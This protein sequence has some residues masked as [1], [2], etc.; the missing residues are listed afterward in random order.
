MKKILPLIC[1]LLVSFGAYAAKTPKRFKNPIFNNI[2]WTENKNR[3]NDT[4]LTP[5]YIY[6]LQEPEYD[7]V[8]E[9]ITEDDKGVFLKC[10]DAHPEVFGP[11]IEPSV[12]YDMYYIRDQSFDRKGRPTC[13]VWYCSF[14][15][16]EGYVDFKY[17]ASS[18]LLSSDIP[19]PDEKDHYQG[20]YPPSD[21]DCLEELLQRGWETYL[22]RKI[23]E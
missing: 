6:D 21:P 11:G 17:R 9:Y 4:R 8:C 10:Q 3:A 12:T 23:E 7:E 15:E 22:P 19:C 1:M 5:T 13:M 2:L 14:L 16:R 18:A 20:R